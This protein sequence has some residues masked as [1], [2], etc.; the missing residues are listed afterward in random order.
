[1]IMSKLFKKT[2][3]I[4]IVLF[5]VIALTTLISS[6]WNLYHDLTEEYK[7]KGT[8]I[9]SSIAG[10]S[11]ET[12]LNRDASTVQA[13]IDQFTEI[14]G[15]SY[16][17]VVDAQGE[18]ISHTFI[19]NVPD[20]ILKIQTSKNVAPTDLHI[21]GRGD[22]IDISSP[23]VEGAVGYVHVGMDKGI[24]MS[25]LQAAMIRQIYL[26]SLIFIVSVA[27]AYVFV[28]RVSQPLNKLT[29]Y[30]RKLAQHDFTAQVEIRS[31]DEVGLL[32]DTMQSMAIE[33]SEVFERYELALKDAIIELQNTLAYLT[34][35][36]DHM[37]DGLL[38][39]DIDGIIT[40]VNPALSSMF[41]MRESDLM[42]KSC[43]EVF[44]DDL[45]E[46]IQQSRRNPEAV[47]TTEI[48]LAGGRVGK[49][50][51]TG[52]QHGYFPLEG[53]EKGIGSVIL[54]RDITSEK[55]VD[56]MKT[57]FISTVSHELRTPLTSV[58][59]FTEIIKK[60]LEED[61]LKLVVAHDRKSERAIKRVRDNINIILSESERLTTLIDDLLDIAK[62]ESGK[63]V[64][65]M[66]R[67]SINEVISRAHDA[68]SALFDKKGLVFI[69]RID[70]SLPEFIGDRDKLIQV[71]INLLA[72]A[73][74]FTPAGTVT[75]SAV[76]RNGELLVSVID[77]GI[78]I[79]EGDRASI[80][81]KFK[82]AGDTLTDKPRGTGLGLPIC[83]Q[84]IE[85]HGGRI[86]VESETGKGSIF[87]FTLPLSIASPVEAAASMR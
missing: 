12:L 48:G 73:V 1:M 24:I 14:I 56:R 50:V 46:I 17:F 21:R 11:V 40:H 2:L 20:E 3:L 37:A 52:I 75:C 59:G 54:I 22:F 51:A 84:I 61:I 39:S 80:F 31:K 87:S 35:V 55:E 45:A 43:R 19:P 16:V 85:H 72:N 69:R 15:V 32:A 7:S 28:N 9:A 71:V 68:T 57:D 8:A 66:E 79:A 47:Y 60:K 30:S 44:G 36:I 62:L 25:Q 74:K 53:T 70:E 13:M 64:W 34:T 42:G 5:A 77:S 4:I 63:V 76:R 18:I 78:G 23:I 38:V 41:G 67:I 10:S 27:A 49:A 81:E 33:L 65:K 26:L 82:Q 58:K 29:E 83:K 6:G 86:W